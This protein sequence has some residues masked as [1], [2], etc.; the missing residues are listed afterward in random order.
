MGHGKSRNKEDLRL[1]IVV[2]LAPT[3]SVGAKGLTLRVRDFESVCTVSRRGIGVESAVQ[4]F[5]EQD[6]I[7][8]P[9]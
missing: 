4:Y 2:Y 3:V 7:K 6:F 9:V 5:T 1:L 8:P